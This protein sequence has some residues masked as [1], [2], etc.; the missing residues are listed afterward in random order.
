MSAAETH[1]ARQ[2]EGTLR[3]LLTPLETAGLLGVA[4]ETLNL[5]RC[6]RRVVLPFVHVGRRVR[7][8]P[9]DIEHFIASRTTTTTAGRGAAA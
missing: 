6:T 1:A 7:Y 4:V 2:Y 5:W 3:R 9:E 8:R